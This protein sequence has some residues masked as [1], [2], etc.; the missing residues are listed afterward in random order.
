MAVIEAMPLVEAMPGIEEDERGVFRFRPSPARA[1]QMLAKR[2]TDIRD[3][4]LA[5]TPVER[6][7]FSAFVRKGELVIR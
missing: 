1:R 5:G 4:I 6:G 3:R 2:H 7:P